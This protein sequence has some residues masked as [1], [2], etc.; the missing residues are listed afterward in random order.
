[1]ST[2]C[3]PWT[4]ETIRSPPDLIY[5]LLDK[6]SRSP[7][8]SRTRSRFIR[9]QPSPDTRPVVNP[10][11]FSIRGGPRYGNAVV[12]FLKEVARAQSWFIWTRAPGPTQVGGCSA[13]TCELGHGRIGPRRCGRI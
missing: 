9:G 2:V 12:S 6:T 8:T 5:T 10:G 1:M 4:G 3:V 7:K 13:R 11:A